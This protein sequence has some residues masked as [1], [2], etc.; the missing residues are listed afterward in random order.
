MIDRSSLYKGLSCAAWGYLFL[1]L[2]F[3]LGNVSILPRF[4]GWLLFLRAIDELKEERRDLALLRPLGVLLAL[5][6]GAD[7]LASWTGRDVDGHLPPLDLVVA[8]AQLYF[9][10]Q[11]LT[12]M[13]ALARAYCREPEAADLSRRILR[14]RTVQTVLVTAIALSPYLPRP[15]RLPSG[16]I[17]DGAVTVL[18]LVYAL[19][20]IVLMLYLFRLRGAFKDAA[21]PPLPPAS[22]G[23]TGEI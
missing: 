10:F 8:V 12:D 3:N 15:G 19:L 20:G 4:V 9:L 18:A 2:D 7:W 21:P 11:F 13:A 16:L 22:G 1:N 17:M 6:S 5:W 14:C 23:G